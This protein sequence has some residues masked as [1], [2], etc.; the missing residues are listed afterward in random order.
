MWPCCTNFQYIFTLII[1]C[2]CFCYDRQ[3]WWTNYYYFGVALVFQMTNCNCFSW[4]KWFPGILL[5]GCRL[6]KG[7]HWNHFSRG[8]TFPDTPANVAVSDTTYYHL[9]LSSHCYCERILLY[10]G[11]NNNQ[12]NDYKVQFYHGGGKWCGKSYEGNKTQY[13]LPL[14]TIHTYIVYCYLQS[15]Y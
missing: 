11:S 13:P 5:T 6:G 2:Y 8:Y 7:S 9:P 4:E 10:D 12:Y 14:I 15:L 1:C 3:W